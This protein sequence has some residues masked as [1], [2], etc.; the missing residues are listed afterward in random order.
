M[1][2]GKKDDKWEKDRVK[3]ER[4]LKFSSL[5]QAMFP[6]KEPFK[7]MFNPLNVPIL[8]IL[9]VETRG[10]MAGSIRLERQ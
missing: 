5:D 3:M 10:T 6:E 4:H 1:V 7:R 9:A 2:T 8:D